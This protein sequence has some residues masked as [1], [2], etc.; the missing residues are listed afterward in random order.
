MSQSCAASLYLKRSVVLFKIVYLLDAA[1]F[2]VDR[3]SAAISFSIRPRP[4]P[5]PKSDFA[6]RRMSSTTKWQ[7]YM[8]LQLLP[9]IPPILFNYIRKVVQIIDVAGVL[10]WCGVQLISGNIRPILRMVR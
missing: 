3:A 1:L 10:V 5:P 8:A 7:R 9:T 2:V 6:R 4:P